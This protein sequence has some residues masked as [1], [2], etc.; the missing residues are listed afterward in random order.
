[1]IYLEVPKKL[2]MLI[3]Q[4]R[5]TADHVF[6]PISRKYDRAEHD[7][8]I[9]LDMFAA[10]M[11][12]MNDA[13][14]DGGAGSCKLRQGKRDSSQIQNGINMTTV[15]GLAEL[16][17]GDVG[18]SLT[19]PRQGLGHAAIEAMPKPWRGRVRNTTA[20]Q[21]TSSDCGLL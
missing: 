10:I 8:P 9:E 18:L 1:M 4:A 6:R 20:S 5:Q 21:R 14:E 7:Y 13:L 11:D 19:M 16:C 17:R 12:G 3:D 2:R 15:L